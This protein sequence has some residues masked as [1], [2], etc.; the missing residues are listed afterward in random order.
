[1]DLVRH[2]SDNPQ[3]RGYGVSS[4]SHNFASVYNILD[5]A[6][7]C[8]SRAVGVVSLIAGGWSFLSFLERQLRF[9]FPHSE[10]LSS[11]SKF[12]RQL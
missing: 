9:Y 2:D 7:A 12:W 6:F 11:F 8:L 4:L 10:I 3:E 1:M 5:Q